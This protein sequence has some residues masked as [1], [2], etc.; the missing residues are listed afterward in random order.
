MKIAT[1][2]EERPPEV[3]TFAAAFAV[4]GEKQEMAADQE[5]LVLL[6]RFSGIPT[7]KRRSW[8]STVLK[9][10]KMNST[11]MSMGSISPSDKGTGSW[12]ILPTLEP[13][14]ACPFDEPRGEDQHG[15]H[16]HPPL[17][18]QGV[19]ELTPFKLMAAS[20]FGPG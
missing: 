11:K 18:Q 4:A 8:N 3:D 13:S 15:E 20:D 1:G 16:D 19:D 12:E 9:K 7:L 5:T 10:S 2:K 14:P 17:L 6:K